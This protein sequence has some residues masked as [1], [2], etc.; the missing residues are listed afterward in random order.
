M[1]RKLLALNL[2][3]ALGACSNGASDSASSDTTNTISSSDLVLPSQISLVEPKASD[4]NQAPAFLAQAP[5]S[6]GGFLETGTDYSDA[7]QRSHVWL[8]ALEPL[9]TVDSIL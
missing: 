8:E 1:T 9:A 2:C 7:P 5:A 4:T 6:E 3:L